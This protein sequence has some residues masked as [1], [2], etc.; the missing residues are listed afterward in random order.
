MNV[1][2]DKGKDEMASRN[3][4]DAD[5]DDTLFSKESAATFNAIIDETLQYETDPDDEI[6]FDEPDYGP[7]PF[8]AGGERETMFQTLPE[9]ELIF[10]NEYIM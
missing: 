1:I 6:D 3:N 8:D 2:D 10:E 7:E 5:L 4:S 9:M